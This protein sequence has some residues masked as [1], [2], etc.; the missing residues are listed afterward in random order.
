MFAFVCVAPIHTRGAVFYAPQAQGAGQEGTLGFGAALAK[1][2]EKEK[3]KE[4]GA[5]KDARHTA[6]AGKAS[7]E[8][9]SEKSVEKHRHGSKE[10]K[11]K[12]GDGGWGA[13]GSGERG[14]SSTDSDRK[15]SSKHSRDRDRDQDRDRDKDRDRGRDRARDRTKSKKDVTGAENATKSQRQSATGGGEDMGALR[16]AWRDGLLSLGPHQFRTLVG[17]HWS[18]LVAEELGEVPVGSAA[19]AIADASGAVNPS[20]VRRVA[21]AELKQLL[22]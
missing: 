13:A 3:E 22:G 20:S 8:K 5:R 6:T 21:M 15:S 19:S 2:A 9:S 17:A 16:T 11:R 4:K 10:G 1:L 18:V 14:R 7:K 12:H